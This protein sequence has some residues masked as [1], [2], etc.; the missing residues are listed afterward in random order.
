MAKTGLVSFTGL[1]PASLE[2]S[3]AKR[4]NRAVDT[5]AEMLL[6]KTLHKMGLRFRKNVAALP[7][8]PDVV[9]TL[10]KV[11]VFCDGDF[12]HG[13][14]W[15]S[16]ERKLAGGTNSAYW[17]AKIRA[18]ILRDRATNRRLK[19]LGWQVIRVWETDVLRN[20]TATAERVSHAVRSHAG[21]PRVASSERGRPRR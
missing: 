1:K 3:R 4:A 16:L 11:V 2:A 19:Q 7:G 10:A 12:W 20:P 9:F 21:A 8:K 17:T 5:K 14:K 13:R 15:R 18:N 6:R